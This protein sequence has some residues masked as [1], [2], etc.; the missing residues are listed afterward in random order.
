MR[1]EILCLIFLYNFISGYLIGKICDKNLIYLCILVS[2]YNFLYIYIYT[3]ILQII[4]VVL[5]NKIFQHRCKF[6]IA[7]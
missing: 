6:M 5:Y 3:E 1:Q 4:V 7:A 2:I